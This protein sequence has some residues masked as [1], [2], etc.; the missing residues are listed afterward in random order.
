M[1]APFLDHLNAG[2][3]A[4]R[5]LENYRQLARGYDGTCKRIEGLRLRAVQELALRPGDTVFDLACGTGPTLPALADAVGPRGSVVGIELSPEMALQAR[6]RVAVAG[7]EGM[8]DVIES[9]VEAFQ[10]GRAADA[11]L[12]CY[13]HDVLQ[14]PAALDRLLE[15]AKPGARIVLLGMKTLPWLWG[16]PVNVV[17]LYRARRYL[18]TYR[19][20]C[21]PWH[22]LEQRGATLHQVHSALWGS[23]YIA[24]GTLPPQGPTF[25]PDG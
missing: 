14:S 24:S 8:V 16:W 12:L 5:A 15:S 23:A 19:N 11:L 2:P 3:D 18:T 6:R 22:L 4:A 20:L 7:L 17:N 21:R 13:T 1:R 9:A 10:V 25:A